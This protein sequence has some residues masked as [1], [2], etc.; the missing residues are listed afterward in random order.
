MAR[1]MLA[2]FKGQGAISFPSEWARGEIWS[3]QIGKNEARIRF[4]NGE[5]FGVRVNPGAEQFVYRL[6]E[7]E[8][9]ATFW[10]KLESPPWVP[11]KVT[12]F[13]GC[14]KPYPLEK[15]LDS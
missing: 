4:P 11:Y 3:T 8:K 7:E 15:L 5:A 9:R 1:L 13:M 10:G 2:C 14:V 12:K 6:T